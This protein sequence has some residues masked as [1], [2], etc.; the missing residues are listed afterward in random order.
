MWI[1]ELL[2]NIEQGFACISYNCAF[3]YN[4]LD[5]FRL[6]QEQ[7][8]RHLKTRDTGEARE[9]KSMLVSRSGRS[10]AFFFSSLKQIITD[11]T[12]SARA[13]PLSQLP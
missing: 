7:T 10:T 2:K 5:H 6:Y 13:V 9:K 1:S 12:D 11:H 3:L 4:C 8:N